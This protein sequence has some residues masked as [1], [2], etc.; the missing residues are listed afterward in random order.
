MVA[1]AEDTGQQEEISGGTEV[2]IRIE[3]INDHDDVA[4]E[5]DHLNLTIL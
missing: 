2:D 4:S 1:E 5:N 3:G